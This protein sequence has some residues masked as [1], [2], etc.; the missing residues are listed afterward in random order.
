MYFGTVADS[1]E[2]TTMSLHDFDLLTSSDL[3]LGSRSCK[4]YFYTSVMPIHYMCNM[5]GYIDRKESSLPVTNK[6]IHV[7][8]INF[9][10]SFIIY[11]AN[12]QPHTNIQ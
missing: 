5:P 10:Y 3:D 7:L 4:V 1:A 8:C 6:R 12:W 2:A 11:Y 9:M